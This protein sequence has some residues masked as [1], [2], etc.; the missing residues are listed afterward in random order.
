MSAA[1]VVEV[2]PVQAREREKLR[3]IRAK[4]IASIE[5]ARAGDPS[6]LEWQKLTR[7]SRMVFLMMAGIDGEVTALAMKAWREFTPPE[8]RAV[9]VAIRAIKRDLEKLYVLA[10]L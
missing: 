2:S 8:K 6:S 5:G 3:E 1:A 10:M 9:A 4:T 7:E